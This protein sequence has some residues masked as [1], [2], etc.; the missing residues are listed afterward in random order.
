M[1]YL[2]KVKKLWWSFHF[3]HYFSCLFPAPLPEVYLITSSVT[4]LKLNSNGQL[5]NQVTTSNNSKI[6]LS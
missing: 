4:T 3:L 5:S 1:G 2:L 6:L